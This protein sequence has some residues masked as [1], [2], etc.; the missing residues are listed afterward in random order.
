V[1]NSLEW[2][3]MAKSPSKPAQTLKKPLLVSIPLTYMRNQ[4]KLKSFIKKSRLSTKG[5]INPLV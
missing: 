1:V 5:N 3:F 2:V 4:H